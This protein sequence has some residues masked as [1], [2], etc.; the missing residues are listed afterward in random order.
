[1]NIM[2]NSVSRK[3]AKIALKKGKFYL[4]DVNSKYGTLVYEKDVEVKLSKNKS[5]VVQVGNM[6]FGFK[7]LQPPY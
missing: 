2:E 4:E 3:H 7:V 5:R 1:M 6:A